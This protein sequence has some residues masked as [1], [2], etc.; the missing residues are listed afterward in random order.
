MCGETNDR[1]DYLVRF[2]YAVSF[3]C[4]LCLCDKGWSSLPGMG[5]GG[6]LHKGNLCPASRQ[7]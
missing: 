2:S 4:H 5:Q 7:I 6:H 3:R 1:K